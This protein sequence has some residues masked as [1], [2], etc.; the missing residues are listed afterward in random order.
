M[1]PNYHPSNKPQNIHVPSLG[2]VALQS[3]NSYKQ[4]IHQSQDSKLVYDNTC[5]RSK[6]LCLF[7]NK[8]SLRC[9]GSSEAHGRANK[10]NVASHATENHI[11]C[12]MTHLQEN[13]Q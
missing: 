3:G 7:G 12:E 4:G 1:V 6:R 9:R 8:L 5:M 2:L 13:K 11:N 10:E